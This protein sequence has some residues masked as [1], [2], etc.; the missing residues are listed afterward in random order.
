MCPWPALRQQGPCSPAQARTR[1]PGGWHDAHS[2]MLGAM[3]EFPSHFLKQPWEPHA[4]R[5][6]HVN[7]VSPWFSKSEKISAHKRGWL[8]PCVAVH[9]ASAFL[10]RV[11]HFVGQWHPAG[12]TQM[13]PCGWGWAPCGQGWA[14]GRPPGSKLGFC[15]LRVGCWAIGRPPRLQLGFAT[16]GGA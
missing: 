11:P 1:G 6:R 12:P 3:V 7:G 9:L 8:P 14:I 2:S 15:T 4:P 13:A 10:A 5:E 16:C